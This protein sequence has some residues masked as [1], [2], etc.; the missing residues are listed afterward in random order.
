MSAEIH[1]TSQDA[2]QL[3][4]HLAPW[5]ESYVLETATVLSSIVRLPHRRRARG[6]EPE[7]SQRVRGIEPPYARWEGAVLPLNYTRKG[8]RSSIGELGL[9]RKIIA[10]K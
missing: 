8:S 4:R 2:S 1:R 6:D 3:R 5:L 10:R 9:A 7:F